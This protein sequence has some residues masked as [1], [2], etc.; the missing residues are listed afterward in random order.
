MNN[1][2]IE[3]ETNTNNGFTMSKE[4]YEYLVTNGDKIFNDMFGDLFDILE[5]ISNK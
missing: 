4:D 1:N 2:I 5:N 3:K